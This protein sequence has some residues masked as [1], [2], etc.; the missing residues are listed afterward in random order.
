MKESHLITTSQQAVQ[1]LALERPDWLP[2]LEAAVVV[3]ATSEGYG[4]EF[5]G[6]AVLDE[7]AKRGQ[8]RWIPNLRILVSYG[9]I[10]K[11]GRSTR[12][13]R[14]AYYRMP[15]RVA[16]EQALAEWHAKQGDDQPRALQFIAAG[17]SS[18]QPVDTARRAGE[19][20]YE[21]RSWR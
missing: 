16:V 6:A 10:E 9:L 12:G 8:R 3:A 7:L 5:P 21:P 19:I 13:G 15:Q 20:A 4:G 2:V 1:R 17:S 11:S 14:R 18:D